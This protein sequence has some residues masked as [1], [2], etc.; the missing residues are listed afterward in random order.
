MRQ[1][2]YNSIRTKRRVNFKPRHTVLQLQRYQNELTQL[3]YLLDRNPQE[4]Q[5]ELTQRVLQ[6]SGLVA[7]TKRA[8][9]A[10][11]VIYSNFRHTIPNTIVS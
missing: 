2:G 8:L 9:D 11:T 7:Q 6:V 4:E 1:S 3:R 10:R 5:Q